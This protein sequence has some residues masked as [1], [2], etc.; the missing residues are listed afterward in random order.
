MKKSRLFGNMKTA[1]KLILIVIPLGI[2]CVLLMLQYSNGVKSTY[3]ELRTSLYDKL[4]VSTTHL[5]QADRGMYQ[6]AV[7]LKRGS[8]STDM[9]EQ[10][11]KFLATEYKQ[12]ALQVQD[13]VM[14]AVKLF[15]DDVYVYKEYKEV[16][17]QMTLKEMHEEFTTQFSSWQSTY[18]IAT[19][20]GNPELQDQLFSKT[21]S[22]I[23][24]MAKLVNDYTVEH[25]EKQ[26]AETNRT[27]LMNTIVFVALLGIVGLFSLMVM[28]YLGNKVRYATKVCT[29]I[30]NGNFNVTIDPN[31]VSRDELGQLCKATD[32]IIL[33]LNG[34]VSYITEITQVLN[35]MSD[36]ILK[37]ELTQ[38]YLG[39]FAPVR[40]AME[41]L[42][43][44]LKTALLRISNATM[45]VRSGSDQIS[46]AAQTLAEGA[47][48]QAGTVQEIAA[49]IEEL[50]GQVADTAENA[51]IASGL[52]Q[53]TEAKSIEGADQM[54]QL[55]HAVAAISDASD[56]IS[57]INKVIEDIAFQTNIL[58]LNASVEAARAG[59][60][61]KG[62]AVVAEEVRSLAAKS[63]EASKT[64]SELIS[65][66]LIKVD[67][68]EKIAHATSDSLN[69]IVEDI[70]KT[71]D[72]IQSIT[73]AAEQ[74]S[75]ALQQVNTGIEQ[76]SSVVQRNSA[77]AEENAA[78]S[79]ELS[80]QANVLGSAVDAFK[81]D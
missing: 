16:E 58:A 77:T 38:D 67:E 61:G 68:G 53:A 54:Q 33:R 27:I 22:L 37:I 19:G 42:S 71:T 18:N 25:I 34:Y 46:V 73:L 7:M 62:F 80:S 29:E 35:T 48:E 43:E 76:I 8:L 5:L 14:A 21:R 45:Q 72:L 59:A 31:A 40:A 6:C 20:K 47:S 1:V 17:R 65:N 28:R 75:L 2:L 13:D 56:A 52:V 32:N 69:A 70:R 60:A 57:K 41:S 15:Y 4:Y 66:S 49:T 11:R 63:A 81:L 50:S 12:T 9:T 10:L 26:D 79:V 39:E 3:S 51:K 78:A 74:E 64:T 23:A 24:S 55:M 36:G 30:A 44:K